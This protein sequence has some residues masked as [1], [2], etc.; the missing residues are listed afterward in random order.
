[1]RF[2]KVITEIL[3]SIL[4]SKG[5]QCS[6]ER[7]VFGDRPLEKSICHDPELRHLS[8]QTQIR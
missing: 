5:S 7:S 4:K 1:M 8:H 2:L 6:F 3:N